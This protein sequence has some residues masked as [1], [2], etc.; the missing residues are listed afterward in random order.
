M[1]PDS[2]AGTPRPARAARYEDAELL[3][4][5]FLSRDPRDREALVQRFLPLARHLSRKY[6]SSAADREDLEQVASLGLLKAIERFDPSLGIAFSSFA[7]PTII[8]ELKRYFR[9]H[10]WSVRVPRSLKELASRV[11]AATHDLERELGRSPTVAETAHRC[12]TTSE[13]VLEARALTTAHRAASLDVPVG[14]RGRRVRARRTDRRSRPA[15]RAAAA[16]RASDPAPA[17]PR[18]PHAT[19]DRKPARPVS[20]AR[21]TA[22]QGRDRRTPRAG[23]RARTGRDSP[24]SDAIVARTFRGCRA[25]RR[26]ARRRTPSGGTSFAAHGNVHLTSFHC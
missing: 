17:L 6:A 12:Q 1:A 5:Y 13:M 14:R 2:L 24:A 18:G 3:Q 7:V 9:D 11:D 23:T 25:L 15:A 8:G 21:L 22:D 19:R 20:D 10:G 16:A 4:R 26:G